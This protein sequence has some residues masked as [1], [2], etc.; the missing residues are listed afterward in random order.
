M[1]LSFH[2]CGEI[3]DKEKLSELIEEV[4]TLA[5][6]H[7][8]KYEIYNSN[9]SL[10]PTNEDDLRQKLYGISFTPPHCEEVDICFLENG[11]MSN[12]VNLISWGQS[13]KPKEQEYLYMLSVKTQY[14]GLETHA[15][16][17]DFFRF[18]AAKYLKN[19]TLT[20]EGTYWE[21]N[22]L[23]ALKTQFERYNSIL[24]TLTLGLTTIAPS[25]NE[26]LIEYLERVALK[27]NNYLKTKK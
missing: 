7:A 15:I 1:G 14:A 6:T 11:K 10:N 9:F 21:S 19:F 24:D 3:K 2:Y 5:Q 13:Q 16:I 23:S 12:L 22:D 4:K 20:D 27:T 26:S 18:I 8:W 25:T 17:I